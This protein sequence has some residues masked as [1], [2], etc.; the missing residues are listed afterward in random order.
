MKRLLLLSFIFSAFLLNAQNVIQVNA[1]ITGNTTWE[2]KNIYVLTGASF[3]YVKNDAVL[4]IEAGTIIKGDPAALVITRGSKIIANGEAEK[5]IVFTSNKPAGQRAPGDWGGLLI[6][7]KAKVNCPGG[8]CTI[9]GGLDPVLGKY[10]GQDDADNSGTLRYVRVE[11]AGIAFQPNNETNSLTLGGVGSGTT[12]DH[13]QTSFGGDDAFE[14]FGGTVNGKYLVA[15]K[16]VDDMFDTDFGFTGNVQYGLG[17]SDP[18]LADISGSNA[19]EADNDAQ[20]STNTPISRGVFSNMTIIGPR[21]DA[22]STFNTNFRRG[23]HLRRSTQ[24]NIVNSIISGFP[25]GIRLESANSENYYLNSKELQLRNNIVAS[26]G[27]LFDSTSTTTQIISD[28]FR[29]QN[30][31]LNTYGELNLTAPFSAIVNP[32]PATGSPALSGSSF[33]AMPAFFERTNYVGGFGANNW[34]NCWCEQDPVNADYSKSPLEYIESAININAQINAGEVK[35][36]TSATSNYTYS[37]VFGDGGTSTEA[38]PTYTY[39]KSG[40]YTVTLTVSNARGCTKTTTKTVDIITQQ[41]V[42]LVSSDITVDTKWESKN[43]YVLTGTAFIYVKNNATL[44]IEAGTII[45]GE[46]AALVI[47]RGSKIIADGLPNKPIV[48]TSNKA[49]GQ[50]TPGDWGGLL[51]LGNAKV[52]CPGGECNVEG[53]LD[54]VLG[55]YGGQNDADNSGVLRYVRIEF[56]GIAFQPNN[57][58]NSLTLGGV[59]SSTVIEHVQTSFGGDDAFEWFGGTVNGK[60]LMAY[61]TIDDMFDTDFGF[62]GN[63]QYALGISDP[64]LAD[65]SGSNAFEA[66]NDAQGTTNAPQSQSIF[67]NV[68]IIGP[69]ENSSSTFNT[70]FRR[71]IHLRRSTKE[72]IVNSIIGGFPTGVRLESTNSENYF[73]TSKELKLNGNIFTSNGKLFDST[74]VNTKTISDEVVKQNRVLASWAEAG[75]TAPYAAKSNPLPTAS[76]PALSGSEFTG[77]PAWFE[78]TSYVGAFSTNN[79][80][81]CWAEYNPANAD[82]STSPLEYFS[83]IL[84]INSNAVNGTVAFGINNP[85]NYSYSWDFGDQSAKSTVANPSHTYTTSGR[86]T[87]VLSLTNDRGCVRELRTVVDVLTATNNPTDNSSIEVLPNPNNGNFRLMV[88]SPFTSDMKV[89]LINSIGQI[90]RTHTTKVQAGQESFDVNYL[91][92]GMYTVKVTLGSKQMVKK[93]Q[94]M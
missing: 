51:L 16:T 27:K 12:I 71:G 9:E 80:T 62:T 7:G 38:N 14:W 74:S 22:S 39:K 77:L 66:D 19:F 86:F 28:S 61:K 2:S 37:W 50:R 83:E 33:A 76:S 5:P 58:T 13:V 47:T 25:T 93:M 64:N 6:L 31:V 72:S 84:S 94:V 73:L 79:W 34:T 26:V 78:R 59:G 68:T 63:V 55:K 17:V 49:A 40:K 46:P 23:A 36:T 70:N 60:Y 8:E 85:G 24:Q 67:S 89:E 18:N 44:T 53:G 35:F 20:G 91:S 45:K 42:I 21:Q 43:I 88:Q 11:F 1:D 87:V 3:I 52:N 41:N 75:L 10:G 56:A 69:R 90:I 30:R 57:E 92:K 65:I 29:L 81:D 15:Y 54:P 48:F 32:V 4:T 82:Y